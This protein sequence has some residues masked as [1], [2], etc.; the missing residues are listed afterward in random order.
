MLPALPWASLVSPTGD[1]RKGRISREIKA[2]GRE[3]SIT[4]SIL[5]GFYFYFFNPVLGDEK[6]GS[7]KDPRDVNAMDKS[8]TTLGGTGRCV[9]KQSKGKLTKKPLTCWLALLQSCFT[10][11]DFEVLHFLGVLQEQQS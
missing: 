4:F 7:R 1:E 3:M 8:A 5:S 11:E 9:Q 10:A 2:V 6:H